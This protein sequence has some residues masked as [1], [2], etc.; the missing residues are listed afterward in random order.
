M[1]SPYT[2]RI[3]FSRQAKLR[4]KF[5]ASYSHY[6]GL[7][8]KFC[9]FFCMFTSNIVFNYSIYEIYILI[10][11][12]FS[13]VWIYNSLHTLYRNKNPK[14]VIIKQPI[15]FQRKSS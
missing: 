14:K 1:P 12:K 9:I 4:L 10:K 6:S 7:K 2:G 13:D 3:N 8:L 5:G 11:T 15:S